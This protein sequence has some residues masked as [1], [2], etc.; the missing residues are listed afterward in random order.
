[1]SYHLTILYFLPSSSA[2]I[3]WSLQGPFTCEVTNCQKQL[4]D[5]SDL[6]GHLQ[7]PISKREQVHCPFK[8]CDRS[9]SRPTYLESTNTLQLCM[10]LVHAV[11]LQ[12]LVSL[13]SLLLKA[14]QVKGQMTRGMRRI[15][16][17]LHKWKVYT[18]EICPCFSWSCRQSTWPL[19][20]QYS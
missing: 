4:I 10:S 18:W 7:F 12:F 13:S 15:C 6:L 20:Q 8:D 19:P 5:L 3:F 16:W 1:M 11:F 17:T 14:T 9:F 2:V